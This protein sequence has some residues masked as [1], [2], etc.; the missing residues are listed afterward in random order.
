L[1][2][3]QDTDSICKLY[4]TDEIGI[5][6]TR[7]AVEEADA[8]AT[9][10]LSYAEVRGVLARARRGR[11]I[12]SNRAYD[13]VAA[14]FEDDWPHYFVILVSPEIVREAGGLA[15]KQALTGVDALHLASA[16]SLRAQVPD[17]ISTSTW[18]KRLAAAFLAEG[19]ALAHEVTT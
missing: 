11:R 14:E 10:L 12:G 5:A 1:I 8:L 17:D 6:E 15:A 19:L 16:V 9:S 4:L 2:L 3:Y 7:K 13:R 18:D